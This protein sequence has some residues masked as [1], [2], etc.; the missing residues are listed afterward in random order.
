MLSDLL[1]RKGERRVSEKE[2]F[3]IGRR[4]RSGISW[5]ERGGV[6]IPLF[7]GWLRAFSYARGS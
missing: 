2:L 7:L 5:G 3:G 4:D 6:T 1:G